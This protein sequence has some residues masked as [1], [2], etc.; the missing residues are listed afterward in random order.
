[1]DDNESLDSLLNKYKIDKDKYLNCISNF[2][3]DREN[4]IENDIDISNLICPICYYIL[5]QPR[6]CSS[7]N[8]SHSYCKE[9]I[10]KYLEIN[11]KCPICKNKFENKSKN[12]IE[13]ELHKLEFKC[14]FYKE[15]CNEVI[16]YLEYFNH[17]YS[18]KYN[19]LIYECKIEKYNY[20]KKEFE[21]CNYKGNKEEIKEH[22]KRCGLMKNKCIFCCE[23][24]LKIDLKEHFEN[25]CKL[26][27][28]KYINNDKYIRENKNKIK[29][30]IGIYYYSDG[31]KI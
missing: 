2:Y 3:Y 29:D 17:I 15:G 27:I 7:N 14:V 22:L 13:N 10:D 5:K 30:G 31:D 16:N 24:I 28:Y 25:K 11:N 12:E 18:C 26:G 21:E 19:N 6:F 20:L 4:V 1:M 23:N 8:N 9:C